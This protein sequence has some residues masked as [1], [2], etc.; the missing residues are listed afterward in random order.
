[1]GNFDIEKQ[2]DVLKK[3]ED[4]V[5]KVLKKKE[6]DIE[7]Q[8]IKLDNL[9]DEEL[10]KIYERRRE[11]LKRDAQLIARLRCLGHGTYS[12]IHEKDFFSIAKESR[13]VVSHFFRPTTSRCSILDKHYT[14]LSQR[15]LSTRFVKINVEKAVFLTQRLNI[16][17]IP[18]TILVQDGETVAKLIGFEAFGGTDDFST[19]NVEKILKKF[20]VIRTT[21]T[22]CIRGQKN[23]MEDKNNTS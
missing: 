12:L 20:Q 14:I 4:N 10:D 7:E 16:Q 15:Y 13:F 6:E 8:Y 21:V 1:M 22:C 18:T 17:I 2:S 9:R 19:L 23:E 11:A 5:I 3:I